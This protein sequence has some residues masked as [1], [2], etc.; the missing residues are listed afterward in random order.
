MSGASACDIDGDPNCD[1]AFDLIPGVPYEIPWDREE[2]V[3]LTTGNCCG[4]GVRDA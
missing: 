1:N 4:G 3:I 2:L